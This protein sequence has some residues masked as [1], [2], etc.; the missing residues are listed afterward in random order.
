MTDHVTVK[1]ERKPRRRGNTA[2]S[3]SK[4]NSSSNTTSKSTAQG[5]DEEVSHQH[6]RR[7]ADLPSSSSTV[8]NESIVMAGI[9]RIG[10]PGTDDLNSFPIES[11]RTV[12]IAID[13]GE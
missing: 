1:Q 8:S 10:N 13:F 11:S 12:G 3:K 4:F 2:K 9:G 5:A 7:A 6:R